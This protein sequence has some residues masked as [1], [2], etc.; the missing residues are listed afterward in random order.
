MLTLQL[1]GLAGSSYDK[2]KE[3]YNPPDNF[4]IGTIEEISLFFV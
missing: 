1:G 2:Q 3:D 4:C